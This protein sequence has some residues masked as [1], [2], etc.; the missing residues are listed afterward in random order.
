[1]V[2]KEENKKLIFIIFMMK[3]QQSFYRFVPYLN[4]TIWKKLLLNL[5]LTFMALEEKRWPA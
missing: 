5:M 1:M 4:I 3:A 2:K